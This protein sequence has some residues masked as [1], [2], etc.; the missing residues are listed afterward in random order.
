MTS[1]VSRVA[2]GCEGDIISGGSMARLMVD[3]PRSETQWQQWLTRRARY[4]LALARW[5]VAKAKDDPTFDAAAWLAEALEMLELLP[6]DDER[7]HKAGRP[8]QR[9]FNNRAKAGWEKRA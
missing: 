7:I 4:R 5:A 2:T 6:R 9:T 8:R 3:L 1:N